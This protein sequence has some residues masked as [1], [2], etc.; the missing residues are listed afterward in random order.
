V[1][2]AAL[3]EVLAG[4]DEY[5]ARDAVRA[6][7]EMLRS[8]TH[9]DVDRIG[10]ALALSEAAPGHPSVRVRE[11]IAKACDAFPDPFFDA[12][13]A[14]LAA[15]ADPYVREHAGARRTGTR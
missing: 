1:T 3:E 10:L 9:D 5:A 15:D 8:P 4:S 13:L 6:V 14:V 2:P 7:A 12:A 11:E